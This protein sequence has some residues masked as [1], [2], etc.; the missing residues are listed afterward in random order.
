MQLIWKIKPFSY[1]LVSTNFKIS[2]KIGLYIKTSFK[3]NLINVLVSK[4]GMC[5]FLVPKI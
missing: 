4:F 2:I 1:I 3:Q 5:V